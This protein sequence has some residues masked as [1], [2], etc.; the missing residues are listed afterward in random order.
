MAP[1]SCQSVRSRDH[2][3]DEDV[4]DSDAAPWEEEVSKGKDT[5]ISTVTRLALNMDLGGNEAFCNFEHL[6][7]MPVRNSQVSE[8]SR[9]AL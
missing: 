4:L 2:L 5:P 3:L 6:Y 9:L 8:V 1:R 7:T